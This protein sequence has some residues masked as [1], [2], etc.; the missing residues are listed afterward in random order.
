MSGWVERED[1][2]R[3]EGYDER[4]R[5][6]Q[7]RDCWGG[8]DT[9]DPRTGGICT[10]TLLRLSK[11]SL[12]HIHIWQLDKPTTLDRTAASNFPISSLQLLLHYHS[13]SLFYIPL[14]VAHI[15]SFVSP[16]FSI[17]KFTHSWLQWVTS[18]VPF[19]LYW[20]RCRTHREAAASY[21]WTSVTTVHSFF[22]F[23][24]FTE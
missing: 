13:F 2:E 17:P 9:Y 20:K 10:E 23:F 12:A 24:F 11:L 15:S 5:Q 18:S 6:R 14:L 21:I 7:R 16:S 3:M 8:S 19:T 1:V 22:P 4:R